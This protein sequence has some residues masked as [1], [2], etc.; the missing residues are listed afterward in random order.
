MFPALQSRHAAS[1][2]GNICKLLN[3][4]GCRP[5]QLFCP[6]FFNPATHSYRLRN[7]TNHLLLVSS[8]IQF[9]S[10]DLFMRSLIGAIP[11]IW[12][13]ILM[14]FRLRGANHG[15]STVMKL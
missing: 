2:V 13:A 6:N 3:L 15:W 12:A 9:N 1:A 5:L 4:C 14:E 10:L 11:D 7:L 8:T